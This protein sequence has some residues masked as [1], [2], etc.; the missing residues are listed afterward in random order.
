MAGGTAGLVLSVQTC[1]WLTIEAKHLFKELSGAASPV[2]DLSPDW[3]TFIWSAALSILTG[4]AVGLGPA[5]RASRKDVSG[6]LR[7]SGAAGGREITRRRNVLVTAQVASCLVLLTAA[8]LLFR[9]ATRSPRTDA[10]FDVAHTMLAA[11]IN[12]PIVGLNTGRTR[13]DY[14]Q[15]D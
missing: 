9:G 1:A 15:G 6:A 10:G 7:L 13:G 8:G 11:S 5:L 4:V 3:R 12:V 2:L 14:T